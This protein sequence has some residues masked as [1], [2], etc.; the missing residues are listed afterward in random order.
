MQES[1]KRRKFPEER[2]KTHATADD[3]S[4]PHDL[5]A[6][7]AVIGAMLVD[8]PCVDEAVSRFGAAKV[9][10]S[11]AHQKIYD[12]IIH[13]HETEHSQ[14]DH[15]TVCKSLTDQGVLEEIGGE[16]L[17]AQIESSVSTTAHMETW[18]RIVHDLAVL[19]ELIG[20]CALASEKCF[21]R[22]K[23]VVEILD[24]VERSILGAREI[25][26]KSAIVDVGNYMNYAV[27]YLV[28][29][30]EKN[31]DMI[32][33][34]TGYP[35]FDEKISGLK[36][37]EMI[38]VAARPSV[39]KTS[40]ALN[41]TANVALRKAN[42]R[43]VLFFSMEMTVEQLARRLLCAE[44][45]ICEKDF[46]REVH[47][48]DFSKVTGT[49]GRIKA[50]RIYID[51]TPALRVMELRAKA[52]RWKNTKKI[53]LI[54][55]DYLQLMHADIDS[56]NDNRQIEVS[57]ISSGIKSLA[58]ELNL[59]I[60]VLAQLNRATEQHRDGRPRLS[61]LRESGA[62]EQD[63]DIVAFLHRDTDAQ[64]NAS[65]EEQRNGLDAELIIGKNR[66][67]ETGVQEMLFFPKTMRFG[68]KQKYANAQPNI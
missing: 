60:L 52:R 31:E 17:L 37:G 67:G 16:V 38:V 28:K 63:A 4:L 35:E 36:K 18:C 25:G 9:F 6:E 40:F 62:I 20:A 22:E 49:A 24:E 56:R 33:I 42:P 43:A 39:G 41:I 8:E 19:R 59:P 26:A 13:L 61:N 2:A 27:D 10:Y 48:A 23:P 7:R 3:R 44:S 65:E 34:S 68:A 55:I 14:I 12:T 53:D 15:I 21:D 57:L 11:P 45:G 66:N 50:A 64:R 54:V 1:P 32:G 46:M 51:P 58:K 5:D 47:H 29:L 30:K